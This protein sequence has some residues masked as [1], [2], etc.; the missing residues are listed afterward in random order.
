MQIAGISFQKGFQVLE[1]SIGISYFVNH[2]HDLNGN[3][4]EI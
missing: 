4:E 2:F 3:Y 1:M